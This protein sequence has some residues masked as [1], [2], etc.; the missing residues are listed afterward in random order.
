[1]EAGATSGQIEVGG[2]LLNIRNL[3]RVVFPEAGTTK[4]DLLDYYVRVADALLPHLRDR[5]GSF[6]RFGE[7]LER[8]G[9]PRVVQDACA[10]APTTL[11]RLCITCMQ[12]AER[13]RM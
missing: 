10:A 3:D 2:R 5:P 4:G 8:G 1:M 12:K 11:S 7:V 13:V 9:A 6:S